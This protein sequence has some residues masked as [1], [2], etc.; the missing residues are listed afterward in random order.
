VVDV[1]SIFSA[2]LKAN[3]C[4]IILAHNHPSGNGTPSESDLK[5]TTKIKNAGE[6]LDIQ[7]LD[8]VILLPDGFTSLAD[9]GFL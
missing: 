1:R 6:I 7:V 2:A 3:S 8:H 4:S 5:I 9:G